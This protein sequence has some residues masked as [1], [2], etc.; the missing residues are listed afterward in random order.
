MAHVKRSTLQSAPKIKSKW[1]KH[2][3]YP[4]LCKAQKIS[5]ESARTGSDSESASVPS[6]SGSLFCEPPLSASSANDSVLGNRTRT[7]FKRESYE[8]VKTRFE[9]DSACDG[10]SSTSKRG[11]V[12]FSCADRLVGKLSCPQCKHKTLCFR[13]D[14][15]K[16]CGLAVHG[17]VYCTTC[18][19][20]VEGT[21]G[22]LGWKRKGGVERL[23]Q[24]AGCLLSI[25]VWYGCHI[26]Q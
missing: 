26:F 12:D 15:R 25:S 20:A 9:C 13:T 1:R 6:T 18:E 2:L 23:Q 21:E 19:Q 16:P 22:V 14:R 10:D 17:Y 4:R 7:Q 5:G 11:I 8:I 3:A 24:Q